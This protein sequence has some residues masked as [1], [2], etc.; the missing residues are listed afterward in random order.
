V[1]RERE[2]NGK[3]TTTTHFYLTSYAG[4][5][6]EIAGW[7]RGHWGI[8]TGLHGVLDVVFQEDDSRV[9][10]GHAGANLAMLRRVAVSL[11][12]RAP[13]KK[14]PTAWPFGCMGP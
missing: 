12:Q 5:A 13:G 11:L 3:N 2:V 1:N 7:I 8:A 6:A 10:E 4:P 9:R 14:V